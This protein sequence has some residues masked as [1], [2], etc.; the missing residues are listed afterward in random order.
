[1]THSAKRRVTTLCATAGAFAMSVT[2]AVAQSGEECH[3]DGGSSGCDITGYYDYSENTTYWDQW[4]PDGTGWS[5]ELS[6]DHVP[7]VCGGPGAS[8]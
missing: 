2:P 3:W 7:A 6:G 8:T 1:M 4:C 5:G